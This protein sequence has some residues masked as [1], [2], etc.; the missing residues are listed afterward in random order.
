MDNA[1]ILIID[2]EEHLRETMQIALDAAGYQTETAADG[3]TGLATFG[4]G[5]E[6]DLVLLDQRMPGMDG[7]AVLR[8]MRERD[9]AA[10]IVMVTAYGTI[11]LAVE[12]MKAGAVDFL[13]K[14]F[15]PTVLRR[16]AEAAL[17]RPKEPVTTGET[18]GL[19]R[20]PSMPEPG[21]PLVQFRTMNGF[22]YWD[23][24]LPEGTEETECLRIRRA[25]E[26]RS[27]KSEPFRCIV[28]MTTSVREFVRS[29]T[30]RDFPP[31]DVLWEMLCRTS[32]A[33]YLWQQ[34]E[35]PP[36]V[37]TIYDLTREDLLLV[38][39]VAGLAPGGRW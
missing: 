37:L 24:P 9:P 6:W 36:P 10:R 30:G 17:S 18:S 19:L 20:L 14:P 5:E 23:V 8:Q 21:V 29:E 32:L 11:D 7:I 26:I 39:N 31:D 35:L 33:S 27:G 16:A 4:A 12:A 3:P 25:F 38:R 15:T 28:E 13:R 1:R 34:G 22:S 2:D